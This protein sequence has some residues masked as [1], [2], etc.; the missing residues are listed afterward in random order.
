MQTTICNIANQEE[1]AKFQGYLCTRLVT[2]V[3]EYK[4]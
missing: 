1:T 3:T 4:F 2:Y